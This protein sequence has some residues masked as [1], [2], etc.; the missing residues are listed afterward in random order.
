MGEVRWRQLVT[1]VSLRP[2][3]L[4]PNL[5]FS[6]YVP[7]RA[8]ST[9]FCPEVWQPD[10]DWNPGLTEALYSNIPVTLHRVLNPILPNPKANM[11]DRDF[12]RD[13][14]VSPFRQHPH[15]PPTHRPLRHL[16]KGSPETLIHPRPDTHAAR[17]HGPATPPRQDC[18]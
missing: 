4:F 12:P 10:G 6:I 5:S 7:L 13:E 14:P 15:H 9:V 16:A 11:P 17:S 2:V 3:G 8:P 18:R 1:R